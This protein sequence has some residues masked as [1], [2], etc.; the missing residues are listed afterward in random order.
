MNKRKSCCREV[1]THICENLDQDLASPRCRD[2]RKHLDGCPDCSIY[3]DSLKKTIT[4]YRKYP[5]PKISPKARKSLYGALI[6]NR[7]KITR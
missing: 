1:F 3:L 7:I 6:L 2:I 4:L 5:K